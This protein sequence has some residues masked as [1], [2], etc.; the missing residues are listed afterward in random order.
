MKIL[1]T[2]GGTKVPID[3]VRHI[4]N[5][6]TGRYGSEIADYLIPLLWKETYPF[7]PITL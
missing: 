3:S 6:S 7:N 4:G 1:I 5:F 2:S